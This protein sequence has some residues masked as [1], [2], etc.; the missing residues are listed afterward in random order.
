M[1]AKTNVLIIHTTTPSEEMARELARLLVVKKLAAC[2][3]V[4][5]PISSFYQWKDKLA[6]DK[7]WI[8]L[9]KCPE[10]HFRDIEETILSIHSYEVPEIIATNVSNGYGPYL[11]WVQN[12]MPQL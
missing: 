6:E 10:S 2:V 7:E 3:Q 8:C 5:G 12:V 4:V 9:I 11:E 1:I